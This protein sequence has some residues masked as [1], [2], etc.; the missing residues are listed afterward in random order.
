MSEANNA[1]HLGIAKAARNRHMIKLYQSLIPQYHRLSL[2]LLSSAKSWSEHYKQYFADLLGEHEALIDA[3]IA[4]DTERADRQAQT[5]AGLIGKRLEAYIWSALSN[6]I[7]ISD[8][9]KAS[10]G[11]KT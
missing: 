4:E 9:R 10:I 7:Q 1:F 2:S 3:I 8:P 5:H 6:P 11:R